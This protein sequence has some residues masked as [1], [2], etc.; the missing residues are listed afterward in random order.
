MNSGRFLFHFVRFSP[1]F[2]L[3]G[4]N[5]RRIAV[6]PAV[7]AG[8]ASTKGGIF[9]LHA[10]LAENERERPRIIIQHTHDKTRCGIFRSC[11]V[12]VLK[13]RSQPQSVVCSRVVE[14]T[15]IILAKSGGGREAATHTHVVWACFEGGKR[16]NIT[17]AHT[18]TH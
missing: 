16:R 4:G 5:A 6:R 9:R 12:C 1:L 15:M 11:V 7:V 10:R 17:V 3:K 14:R 2:G 18:H 8:Q 13:W